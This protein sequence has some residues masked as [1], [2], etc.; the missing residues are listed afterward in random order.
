M[1]KSVA[2]LFIKLRGFLP[3]LGGGLVIPLVIHIGHCID[4]SIPLLQNI[5]HTPHKYGLIIN[6]VRHGVLINFKRVNF[7]EII[8]SLPRSLAIFPLNTKVPLIGGLAHFRVTSMFDVHIS[9]R[10][11]AWPS[12]L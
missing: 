6:I 9:A 5:R 10:T 11:A 7:L 4:N 8:Q 12:V 3:A 1:P 2:I